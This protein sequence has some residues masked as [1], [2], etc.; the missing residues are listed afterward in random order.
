ML[1]R[2]LQ[3]S[4]LAALALV[5]VPAL[6]QGYPRGPITLVIP[7]AAGDAADVAGRLLAEDLAKILG[8]AFVIVNKPGA[9]SVI[10]AADVARAKKDGQTL[11]F[12]VNSALTFRPVLDPATMAYVV[13]RDLLALGTVARSPA[14]LAV[15]SDA[16]WADFAQLIDHAKRHPGTVRIGNAGVGSSGHIAVETINALTSAQITPVPYTGATPAVTA[17]LG[18][19]ID[20]AVVSLGAIARHVQSGAVRGIVVSSKFPELPKV[21]TMVELGYPQ[22]LLGVWMSLFAPAGVP[23][24]VAD[25]LVP[26]IE[27]AGKNPAI[28]ARLVPLGMTMDYRPPAATIDE[29]RREVDAVT[30]AAKRAGLI[31]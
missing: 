12:T 2:F 25:A 27:K 14:I 7:V 13:E 24:E 17:L 4:A 29:V 5:V 16:P 21:P 6:A 3:I 23:R 30:A 10:G 11:L 18:G 26:A 20:G 8:V 9:G 1:R 19:V 28:A 31:P 22:D 15:R